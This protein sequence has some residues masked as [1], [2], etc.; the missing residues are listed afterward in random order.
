MKRPVLCGLAVTSMLAMLALT[1]C[2]KDEPPPPLPTAPSQAAAPPQQ[3]ELQPLAE[4]VP[5]A[6]APATVKKAGVASKPSIAACCAALEQNAA[7]APEPNATYMKQAAAFCKSQGAANPQI[8]AIL[9]GI[10]KG[11]N[12]PTTCK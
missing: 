2:K 10:L 8:V 6:G 7:S 12:L 1:S 4:A 5:D 11:A 9:Q 3:V